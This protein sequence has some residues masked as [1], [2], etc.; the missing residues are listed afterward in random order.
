[1]SCNTFSSINIPHLYAPRLNILSLGGGV[2]F[3]L[4]GMRGKKLFHAGHDLKNE[5]RN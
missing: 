5:K 3:M 2:F 4:P 1:M